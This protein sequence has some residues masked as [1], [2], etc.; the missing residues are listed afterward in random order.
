MIS[1]VIVNYNGLHYLKPCLESIYNQTYLDFEVI[2]V[3]NASCDDSIVYIEEQY[4]DVRIVR[5]TTNRG[6]AGGSND[7]IKE[8][9]GE[10]VF[11]LNT[12][13]VLPSLTLEKLFV[14]T[15]QNSSYG[16]YA[17]KMLYPDGRINS[18]GICVAL[19]GAAWDRGMGEQDIGQ[20]DQIEEVLG[21][22]G[23][24]GLY[25]RSILDLVGGFDEDFFLYMEDVDLAIRIQQLGYHCL[26]VPDASVIHHHG[27]TAGVESD[28]AIYYGNRNILWYPLKN[29]PIWLLFMVIPWIV[30]RTIGVLGY[31]ALRGKGKIAFK[32]KRDGIAGIPKM[33]RK[34]RKNEKNS[35]M[36]NIIMHMHVLASIRQYQ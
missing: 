14:A 30:G 33:L 11:L 27:G 29:Y 25:R 2:L 1:I 19:S 16:M 21:P 23:G 5:N 26:Y 6:F 34:K 22:C 13:T 4:P 12:D 18:T 36:R 32:A 17:T 8:S 35:Y 28:I 31:Y 20:Y 7:G 9:R 15:L 10:Y 24:A 3:D